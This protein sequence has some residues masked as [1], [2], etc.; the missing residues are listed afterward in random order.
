MTLTYTERLVT[1]HTIIYT[2]NDNYR[3]SSVNNLVSVAN[4]AIPPITLGGYAIL[5]GS[6]SA[7]V[8]DHLRVG[9]FGTNLLDK[10]AVLGAPQRVVP[11]L[12]NLADIYSINRPR[13]VSLRVSYD[14]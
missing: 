4:N 1:G 9:L 5:N 12:G 3:G 6:V 7:T 13:E 8:T 10:R 14:W 11:F 2:I